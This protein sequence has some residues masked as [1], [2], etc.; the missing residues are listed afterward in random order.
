MSDTKSCAMP[1][2]V[3]TDFMTLTRFMIEE[4]TRCEGA[5]GE[6]TQ[7]L[8]SIATAVKAISSNV[9]KAGISR[10][11]G[12]AG[13]SNVTG[14]EQKKL[15]IISNDLFISQLK[16]SFTTCALV[17]EENEKVIEVETNRRGKY[18]VTFDPL[19]GSSNIDCLVSIGTIFGIWK[20]EGDPKGEVSSSDVLQ[21][22]SSMV[23]AGYALYGSATM[24]VLSTGCGVNGFQLD[25]AIGEFV[26]TD[27]LITIKS[28]GKIFSINEGYSQY[29]DKSIAKYV[30][31]KKYPGE[32]KSPYGARY[33]GSMVAD[34]HRTIVYGGIFLYPAHKKS[35]TGKLRLL[36]EGA[37]MAFI[38]EQAGGKA[39]TGKER[40]LDIIPS[41]IHQKTPV[42]MGSTFDVDDY[43]AIVKEC[44][45][46]E[47]K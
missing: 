46:E 41:D 29:W 4:Q 28:R 6:M 27:R 32:G 34:M 44:E 3:D 30:E 13:G 17:S 18:I 7:L 25:P 36:Y 43:L 37:P 8:N 1:T 19:D 22:G 16:N 5:T 40:I 33:I 14:D 2:T 20:K 47:K 39:T 35:K 12:I 10:L 38:C 31:S 9:R 26:L 11:Y 15:D 45:A 23:A 42:V 21:P 24:I